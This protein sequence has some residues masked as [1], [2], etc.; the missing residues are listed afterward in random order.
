MA[1]LERKASE[2]SIKSTDSKSSMDSFVIKL[3]LIANDD[4]VA[5]CQTLKMDNGKSL[6]DQRKEISH[7]NKKRPGN[8][9]GITP[10]TNDMEQDYAAYKKESENIATKKKEFEK[11]QSDVDN[12]KKKYGTDPKILRPLL[13]KSLKKAQEWCDAGVEG[14]L[15]RIAFM[16]KFENI[17]N[18]SSTRGH[19]QQAENNLESA[20]AARNEAQA[21]QTGIDKLLSV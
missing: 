20:R 18:K 14:Y 1:T 13:E 10:W 2:S 12:Y 15:K 6:F 11:A 21:L 3:N 7:N 8:D 16:K 4:F 19:I 9:R 17:F 5:W